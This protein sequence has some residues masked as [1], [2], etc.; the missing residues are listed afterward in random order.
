MTH[1]SRSTYTNHCCRCRQCKEA[2]ARYSRGYMA[3]PQ[4]RAYMQQVS[5]DSYYRRKLESLGTGP[6]EP[7]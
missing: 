5:R 3:Q 4:W 2:N 1:G 7:T 6:L